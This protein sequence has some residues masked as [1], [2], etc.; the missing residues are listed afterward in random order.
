MGAWYCGRGGEFVGLGTVYSMG[1][2]I[3]LETWLLGRGRADQRV[4]VVGAGPGVLRRVFVCPT[5]YLRPFT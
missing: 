2:G 1:A 4:V 5:A 3:R